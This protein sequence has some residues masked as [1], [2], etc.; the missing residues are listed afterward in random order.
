MQDLI[1]KALQDVP[2]AYLVLEL[3]RTGPT[4]VSPEEILMNLTP[5]L[6]LSHIQVIELRMRGDIRVIELQL[7]GSPR[8]PAFGARLRG[9]CSWWKVIKGEKDG[10]QFEQI[11]GE[12][13]LHL[14]EIYIAE[15]VHVS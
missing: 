11:S 15:H 9:R 3:S 5:A 7:R 13:G 2:L 12:L 1:T 4:K 8:D 6:R 10:P 14:R